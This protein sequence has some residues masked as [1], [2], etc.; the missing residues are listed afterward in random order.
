MSRRIEVCAA[1]DILLGPTRMPWGQERFAKIVGQVQRA[2]LALGNLECPLVDH[3][4]PLPKID[5]ARADVSMSENLS[6]MGFGALSLGNNHAM[7]YGPEGLKSTLQALKRVKIQAVGAG[8]GVKKAFAPC[9]VNVRGRTIGIV[10]CNLFYLPG[11][12]GYCDDIKAAEGKYG[13]ATIEGRRIRMPANGHGEMVQTVD[14]PQE[15][16]LGVLLTAIRQAKRKA[17][18]VILM[19]HSH[20]GLEAPDVVL[21]GRRLVAREAVDAGADVVIG[22]G[23][24]A[25]N[26]IERHKNAFIVHSLGNLFFDVCV[27][28]V[29][30]WPQ[31]QH[32][33][34]QFYDREV[35]WEGMLARLKLATDSRDYDLEM[36]PYEI[37][38]DSQWRGTPRTMPRKRIDKML[39]RLDQSDT[40]VNFEVMKN[41][42]IKVRA[43][44]KAKV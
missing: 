1:G 32:Y 3:G 17:S 12:E 42:I 23:P 8:L 33:I 22:H 5:I 28:R 29:H 31:N 34:Q 25:L 20:Y 18:F 36:I 15:E 24:H 9:Y 19:L 2:D 4:I 38:K 6:R 13:A 16:D 10:S 21:P 27:E 37:R 44:D 14:G 41:G 35:F 30:F 39:S 11:F 26:P 40:G 43:E 7:D